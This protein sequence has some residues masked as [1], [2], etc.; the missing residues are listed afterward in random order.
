MRVW[1]FINTDVGKVV[2]GGSLVFAAQF[3]VSLVVWF[4]EW[5]FLDSKKKSE[6]AYLAMRLVLVFDELTA[7][8]YRVVHD[9]LGVDEGGFTE[10]TVAD[11]TLS[12]PTDGDYKA[13]PSE[14]MFRIMWMPNR[15]QDI[16]AGLSAVGEDYSPPDFA[17]YFEYREE[18]FAKLGLRAIELVD[19]LCRRYQIPQPDRPDHYSPKESLL[20]ELVRIKHTKTERDARNREMIEGFRSQAAEKSKLAKPS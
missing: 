13:F 14:L 15:L 19:D 2:L 3:V 1:A 6:A 11:P 5:S 17:E 8:C 7:S 18:N 20:E 16:K 10:S 4:K 9:P 12:L